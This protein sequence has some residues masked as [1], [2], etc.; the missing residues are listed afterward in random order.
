MSE[1]P[2]IGRTEELK[3]LEDLWHSDGLS[4]CCV[5][6]RRR[7]GKTRLLEE[8][9][10]GKRTLY[11]QAVQ[12]SYYENLSS[13]AM[14]I[15][16]FRGSDIGELKD[17]SHLMAEIESICSEEHTLV[18]FDEL[19]YLL[20]CAPQA[21]SVIQKSL[22][23]GLKDCR[24]MFVICGS[25]ISVMRKETED[26]GRPLYGRF[27]NSMQIGYISPEESM[28]FYS[29]TS[30]ADALRWYL[31]V[32]GIPQY[33]K[34]MPEGTYES[35]VAERFFGQVSSWKDDA[36]Q[37]ILQEFKG[38]RNY[39]G[40]VKCISDG[41]VKQSEIAEKLGID[42][43]ACKRMLDEL[44]FVNLIERRHPMAGAPKKPTYRIKDPFIAFH[45]GIISKNSKLIETSRSS[46]TTYGLLRMKIDSHLGH[47]FE[48]FCAQWL[49][50]HFTVAEIGSW[51]GRN[52]D[53]EDSDI[54]IIAKTVDDTGLV[55]TLVCECEFSRNPIGFAPLNALTER[56]ESASVRENVK[57]VL[58]SAGG[59]R[60][61]LREYAEENRIILIDSDIL[62]GLKEVPA[63]F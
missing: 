49:E 8:F 62:M 22:D 13:L 17:L 18:V 31:T 50:R 29:G 33:L 11:L 38:N 58:F 37:A 14:D 53:G 15:S 47:M 52:P 40:A 27:G 23:R 30:A 10:K 5:W 28:N 43:A 20:E 51:W 32:G 39:T 25:S 55:H 56:C 7:I 1:G 3:R 34:S 4:T 45:Y 63:L 42:R 57:Y 41:S 26:C 60:D 24:C 16:A 44:E 36:P 12:A 21:A 46:E 59:F 35:G 61:D 19:P 9:S 2:F 54:D 6:G 48:I